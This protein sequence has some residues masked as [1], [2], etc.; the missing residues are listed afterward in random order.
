MGNYLTQVT[1]A[2]TMHALR[3]VFLH[4]YLLPLIGG[5]LLVPAEM[6]AA[7]TGMGIIYDCPN[8]VSFRFATRPEDR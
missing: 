5:T 7:R 3:H 1:G 4:V 2:D 6:E 8:F